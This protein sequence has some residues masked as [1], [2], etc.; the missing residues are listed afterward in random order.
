[1]ATLLPNLTTSVCAKPSKESHALTDRASWARWRS[2]SETPAHVTAG[3]R[4]TKQ[5]RRG[6][7]GDFVRGPFSALT[8]PPD[9]T[10]RLHPNENK[11]SARD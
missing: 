8:K 6:K 1:M 11:S 4:R 3:N 5:H 7:T 2:T 9:L 10:R